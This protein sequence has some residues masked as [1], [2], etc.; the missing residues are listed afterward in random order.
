MTTG[1]SLAAK[2]I[3]YSANMDRDLE[4]RL[5]NFLYQRRCPEE[6]GS[7]GRLSRRRRRE[8]GI[9]HEVRQVAVY[10]VLSS[11]S[12]SDQSH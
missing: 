2:P 11:S 10:R 7:A 6:T 9:S 5:I 1:S 12:W 4:H 8:W 3:L